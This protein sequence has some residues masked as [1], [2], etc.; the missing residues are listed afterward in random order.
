MRKTALYFGLL[1]AVAAWPAAQA[2]TVTYKATLSA[3]AEVPPVTSAGKGSA[4]VTVDPVSKK[5]T[6]RVAFSGLTGPAMAAHIHCGAPAGA[7]AG[8]SV[9]LGKAPNWASPLVGSAT[10]TD[11]QFADL[12]AGKCYANV[13]TAAN[14]SGEIRGQLTP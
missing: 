11:A 4:V 7:N 2:A 8:V 12:Q 5:I 6:W 1:A 14:K 10:M 13:H 3:A 9:P